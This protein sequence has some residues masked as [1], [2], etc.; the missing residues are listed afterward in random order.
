MKQVAGV[1]ITAFC[2]V[3]TVLLIGSYKNALADEEPRGND[4][5]TEF[6]NECVITPGSGKETIL[7]GN[8]VRTTDGARH[9]EL[10]LSD[11]LISG[12]SIDTVLRDSNPDATVIDCGD[13]F[14][15]PGLV[16]PHEHLAH[17]GGIPDPK[18]E[19]I[20]E[21]RDE[22]RGVFGDKYALAFEHVE[23][24]ARDI[25]VE[26]RHLLSGTTTLGASGGV[27]GLVKNATTVTTSDGYLI[28]FEIF[29]YGWESKFHEMDCPAEI[30]DPTP[31]FSESEELLD[32][33]YV[34]HVAEGTNCAATLEGQA[35]LDFVEANPGRRYALLHGVGLDQ[36]SIDRLAG[37]DVS[38]VWSPRSNVSLYDETAKVLDVMESGAL[39]A[40]GT[41]WSYSGSYNMLEEIRCADRVD[42]IRWGDQLSGEDY[43]E[44]STSTAAYSLGLEDE[45][46]QVNLAMA[47]DLVIVQNRTGDFFEDLMDS[48]VSNV[49]ATIIDG[50]IRSGN[51]EFFDTNQLPDQ[52][53]NFIDDHFLCVDWSRYEEAELTMEKVIEENRSFEKA[54][55]LFEPRFQAPCLE[56]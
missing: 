7:I 36:E 4:D 53:Q 12:M 21:H 38:L 25:W 52:C 34:A 37:L 23:G 17:S 5:P 35:F 46:G 19:P 56:D 47:A 50:S 48:E 14:I 45:I 2:A 20:Y 33:P 39:V 24:V 13:A 18:T 41:D 15:S 43:W 16:N 55:P 9:M 11:G 30:E 26:L 10:L 8:V 27:A 42:N 31:R 51:S 22:W 44:M 49:I 6:N 54:V 3:L 1:R 32:Q 29:P 40:L 28:D